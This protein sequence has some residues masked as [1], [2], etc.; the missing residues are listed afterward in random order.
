MPKK[1]RSRT[2][3]TQPGIQESLQ[4]QSAEAPRGYVADELSQLERVALVCSYFCAGHLASE[5]AEL[6]R[7]KHSIEMRRETPYQLVAY[8]ASRGWIKFTAPQEYALAERIKQ[9]YSFLH[10]VR[11]VETSVADDVARVGANALLQLM[12]QLFAGQTVH[13]GFSG[14]YAMR[15]AAR[16]LAELLHEPSPRLPGKIVFHAMVAGFDVFNPT[17]DPNAFFAFLEFGPAIQVETAF[18]GL[19]AP[20]V[21]EPATKSKLRETEGIREAYEHASELDII[22]T[23]ARDWRDEHAVLPRHIQ[24]SLE[25]LKAAGAVG[26]I[27]WQPLGRDGPVE[28]S[29]EPRAM[30]IKTLREVQDFVAEGKQV[31]LVAGPCAEC[32][33]A[34]TEIVGTVLDQQRPLITHLVVDSR[35]AREL[36][37][38]T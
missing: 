17:K 29:S 19:H 30:A 38:S 2:K 13:V 5:I 32:L 1:K 15:Q 20:A 14:G 10:D 23:S 34:K 8:A 33:R 27:L 12:R 3:S 18:V 26:D 11:V 31:L 21:V 24:V 35:C 25:G 37:A 9:K 7:K 6:L 28:L 22:V 4:T 16:Q 36:L